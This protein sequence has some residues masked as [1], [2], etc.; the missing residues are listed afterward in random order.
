MS[1]LASKISGIQIRGPKMPIVPKGATKLNSHYVMGEF[2]GP[3]KGG[4]VSVYMKPDG[5]VHKAVRP[6][7]DQDR[8]NAI[9]DLTDLLAKTGNKAAQEARSITDHSNEEV[10]S[11]NNWKEFGKNRSDDFSTLKSAKSDRTFTLD[12]GS[13]SIVKHEAP[14]EDFLDVLARIGNQ[15]AQARKKANGSFME[16]TFVGTGLDIKKETK[17]GPKVEN[18]VSGLT[19]GTHTVKMSPASIHI[20]GVKVK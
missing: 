10:I 4:A 17:E 2:N 13:T 12:D 19:Y 11:S 18:V 14:V 8:I 3:G 6:A 7:A 1:K 15:A 16:V 9:N 20:D 5:T